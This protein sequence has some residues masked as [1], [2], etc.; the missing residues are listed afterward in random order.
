MD[1][2]QAHANMYGDIIDANVH[3]PLPRFVQMDHLHGRR[4]YRGEDFNDRILGRR[5]HRIEPLIDKVLNDE[6][7]TKRVRTGHGE[8][9]P[10]EANSPESESK[11]M[12]DDP[13]ENEPITQQL[14]QS[15]QPERKVVDI[16]LEIYPGK[17]ED[18]RDGQNQDQSENDFDDLFVCSKG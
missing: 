13:S 2:D 17:G 1:R 3:R 7:A 10:Q 16:Q 15:A 18:D 5:E 9:E 14:A 8:W 4:D 12:I 11:S 6:R